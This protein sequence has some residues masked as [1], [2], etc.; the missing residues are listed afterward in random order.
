[1]ELAENDKMWHEE[2]GTEQPK[3]MIQGADLRTVGVTPGAISTD[4]ETV[5]D[6][7]AAE[8]GGG[9]GVIGAP[10]IGGEVGAA[11]VPSPTG[12]AGGGAAGG[13]TAGAALGGA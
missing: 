4:L 13:Q 12:G 9:V 3:A 8:Q 11:G 5:S 2:R 7:Q 10:P 1:M 6:I